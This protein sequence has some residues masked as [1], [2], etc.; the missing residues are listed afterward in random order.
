MFE[1]IEQL[2]EKVIEGQAKGDGARHC[3]GNPH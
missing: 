3:G 1:K 2:N